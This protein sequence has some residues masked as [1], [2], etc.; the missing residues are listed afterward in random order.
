MSIPHCGIRKIH[1]GGGLA[2]VT[3]LDYIMSVVL[4]VG[5]AVAEWG[6]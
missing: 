5:G 6:G 4:I 3:C 2:I 1:K